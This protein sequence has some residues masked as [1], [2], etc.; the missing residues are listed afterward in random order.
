MV[1]GAKVFE[2]LARFEAPVAP[3]LA[4]ERANRRMPS[5]ER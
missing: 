1:P 3:M 5:I 4:A 2:P